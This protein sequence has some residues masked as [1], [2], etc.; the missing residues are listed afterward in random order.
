MKIRSPSITGSSP[1]ILSTT[2][3]HCCLCVLVISFFCREKD[4]PTKPVIQINFRQENMAK[5][6]LEDHHMYTMTRRCPQFYH[7]GKP[8][9]LDY[10]G[11][12][13]RQTKKDT[14]KTNLQCHGLHGETKQLVKKLERIQF[15]LL[16]GDTSDSASQK[17]E[18]L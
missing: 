15:V 4:V 9:Y 5:L 10:Q 2:D 3:M 11:S 1:Y 12:M 17:D 8:I 18:Q 14:T 16:L 7:I 13:S 6:A